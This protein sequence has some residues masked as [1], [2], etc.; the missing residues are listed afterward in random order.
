MTSLSNDIERYISLS[1]NDP[2][3]IELLY[4][5]LLDH[6]LFVLTNN[7]DLPEGDHTLEEE[8]EISLVAVGMEDG[9]KFIPAFTS[10]EL[11]ES[12]CQ[13]GDQYIKIG[14]VDL[15]AMLIEKNTSDLLVLNPG[16]NLTWPIEYDDLINIFV[17]FGLVEV[18]N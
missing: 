3:S 13:P 18:A 6:E 8:M 9:R 14:S 1:Y 4:G 16:T 15:M 11:L 5:R 10:L 17:H 12:S 7:V 2:P